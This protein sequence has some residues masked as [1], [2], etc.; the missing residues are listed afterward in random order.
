MMGRSREGVAF[1][2]VAAC[3]T[4][5][6]A[7]LLAS[8]GPSRAGLQPPHLLDILCVHHRRQWVPGPETSS[9]TAAGSPVA[10]RSNAAEQ[11]KAQ[12]KF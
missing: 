10:V 9:I 11:V 4:E 7:P 6:D 1:F 8:T 2:R 5:H 3:Q 12:G